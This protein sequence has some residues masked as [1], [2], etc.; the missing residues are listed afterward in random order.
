VQKL[1]EIKQGRIFDD[2]LKVA[3]DAIVIRPLTAS[4]GLKST[5]ITSDPEDSTITISVSS[6]IL[7]NAYLPPAPT[8][9]GNP[10]PTPGG[11]PIP[12]PG[13]PTPAPAPAPAPA[14]GDLNAYETYKNIF[15]IDSCAKAVLLPHGTTHGTKCYD[16]EKDTAVSGDIGK[17]EEHISAA[18]FTLAQVNT[19]VIQTVIPSSPLKSTVDTTV[20]ST[21]ENLATST[22]NKMEVR[23]NKVE[24]EN[25]VAVEVDS[26]TK[27]A[28][29]AEAA[30]NIML[31][32]ISVNPHAKDIEIAAGKNI[33]LG[34]VHGLQAAGA[35]LGI[36][37]QL[38]G[39]LERVAEIN[40]SYPAH[41][42]ELT[43]EI[44]KIT[45]LFDNDGNKQDIGKISTNSPEADRSSA[46]PSDTPITVEMLATSYKL[47]KKNADKENEETES[48]PSPH[49]P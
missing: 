4:S 42:N 39:E 49:G 2:A 7:D 40:N 12:T 20:D 13:N 32:F 35:L 15:N 46:I 14:P 38:T 21:N 41:Q 18:K 47:F 30:I 8:P 33:D 27:L 11:N 1:A 19:E 23:F 24:A 3:H 6:P 9:G 5:T 45:Q 29:Y 36:K 16:K 28:A 26:P 48:S 25:V 44:E 31:N 17:I 10:I 34:Y 43:K 22:A 37:V